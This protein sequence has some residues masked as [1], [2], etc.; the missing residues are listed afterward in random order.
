MNFSLRPHDRVTL[1][2]LWVS[3]AALESIRT[4]ESTRHQISLLDDA[5]KP[6]KHTTSF[7]S[8][9][10][11]VW[12]WLADDSDEGFFAFTTGTVTGDLVSIWEAN[13][14]EIALDYIEGFESS[15]PPQVALIDAAGGLRY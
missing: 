7:V 12:A 2:K 8:T 11:L 1:E 13:G 3:T 6:D 10:D 15:D 9:S 4:F 14:R 5:L